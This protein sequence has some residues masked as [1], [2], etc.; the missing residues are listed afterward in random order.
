M[1]EKRLKTSDSTDFVSLLVNARSDQEVRV[2]SL[3]GA[4]G[5]SYEN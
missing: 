1:P 4:G 2:G 3:Y 5:D